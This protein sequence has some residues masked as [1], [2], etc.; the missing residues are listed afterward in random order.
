MSTLSTNLLV[1]YTSS[2]GGSIPILNN[3]QAAD[4]TLDN[5]EGDFTFESGDTVFGDTVIFLG[6]VELDGVEFLVL[7]EDPFSLFDS[8]GLV[9]NVPDPAAFV[10]NNNLPT[11]LEVTSETALADPSFTTYAEGSG[12]VVCFAEGT[13]IATADGEQ[14][15]EA[16]KVGDLVRTA[17]GHTV[18]VKWIGRQTVQ[19]RF[20]PSVRF[21]PVRIK[22][23]A[24]GD[25]TPHADLT[26]TADHGILVGNVMVNAAA[27]VNGTTIVRVPADQLADRVTYWHIETEH[28]DV[29]VAAG[30]AVETFVDATTRRSFDN[31]DEY[32]AL[33]G[34]PDGQM[35]TLAYPRAF[36]TRQVPEAVKSLIDE[37]VK[38]LAVPTIDVAA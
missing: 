15:V 26:V 1:S 34:E 18:P 24:L 37:Q 12:F 22:A 19:K 36:G 32:V 27:L 25:N 9:A 23:G 4:I 2:S 20:T 35:A 30:A 28:H 33:F 13:P 10:A 8:V 7:R 17:D 16:L 3:V 14:P 6:T 38:H 11:L 5:G 29:I 31:Y 21:C